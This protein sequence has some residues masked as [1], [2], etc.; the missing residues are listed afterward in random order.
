MSPSG[1]GA[2]SS[3]ARRQRPDLARLA[4]APDQARCL[5]PAQTRQLDQ[6]RPHYTPL[7]SSPPIIMLRLQDPFQKLIDGRL[8]LEDKL[9][10]P[11][12]LKKLSH[13]LNAQPLGFVHLEGHSPE[14]S[15]YL[16]LQAHPALESHPFSGLIPHWKS[17]RIAGARNGS[18]R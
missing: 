7:G 11:A 14:A 8:A 12:A 18:L 2:E 5:C 15:A 17:L 6:I 10:L 1:I 3:A 13:L 16:R 4:P 9:Q